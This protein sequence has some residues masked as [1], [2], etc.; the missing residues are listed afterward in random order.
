MD[1]TLDIKWL[2]DKS[3]DKFYPITYIS[4]VRDDDGRSLTGILSDFTN[5]LTFYAS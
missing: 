2:D 3:E 5:K 1:E 4:A